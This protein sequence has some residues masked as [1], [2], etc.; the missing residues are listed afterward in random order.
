[1]PGDNR[2]SG[3]CARMAVVATVNLADE[4]F[5]HDK[6]STP[7]CALSMPNR[8]Y[9]GSPVGWGLAA[10]VQFMPTIKWLLHLAIGAAPEAA[11]GYAQGAHLPRRSVR[12]QLRLSSFAGRG[13]AMDE[14][15]H[16]P[17]TRAL[18]PWQGLAMDHLSGR[19][20]VVTRRPDAH[21]LTVQLLETEGC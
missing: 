6:K 2:C 13:A 1:M 8:N 4:S 10:R 21:T 9:S 11:V 16:P 3:L 18:S 7:A 17:P 14:E 15:A 19:H 20:L 5:S 12:R